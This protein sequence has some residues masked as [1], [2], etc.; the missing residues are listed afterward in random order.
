MP[1]PTQRSLASK[2]LLVSAASAAP[3]AHIK[4]NTSMRQNYRITVDD[5]KQAMDF[6]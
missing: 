5:I 3:P 1:T 2:W 4:W 6:G